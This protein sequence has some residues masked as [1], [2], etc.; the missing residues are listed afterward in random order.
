MRTNEKWKELREKHLGS[1]GSFDP[2]KFQI[3]KPRIRKEDR[4]L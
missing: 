2:L 1:S 4:L 3:Q